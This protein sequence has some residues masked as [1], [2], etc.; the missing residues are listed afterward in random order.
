MPTH[1][2]EAKSAAQLILGRFISLLNWPETECLP[3]NKIG[4]ATHPTC[5]SPMPCIQRFSLSKDNTLCFMHLILST[6]CI[7][8]HYL[9]HYEYKI[10]A[11]SKQFYGRFPLKLNCLRLV[12]VDGQLITCLAHQQL[13]LMMG[14]CPGLLDHK[15]I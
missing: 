6:I 4:H 9:N 12:G 10:Q 14:N 2:H 7:L 1:Q 15:E 13:L 5:M 8:Y 11:E 3:T